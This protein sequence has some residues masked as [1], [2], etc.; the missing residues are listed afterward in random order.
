MERSVLSG[1]VLYG[2]V[3]QQR[4]DTLVNIKLNNHSF[5]NDPKVDDD[6]VF[7]RGST[8]YPLAKFAISDQK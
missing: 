3:N 2:R 4:N 6:V 7:R 1:T 5:Q 8:Y